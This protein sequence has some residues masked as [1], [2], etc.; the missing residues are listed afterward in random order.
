M[1]KHR[2][3]L[4]YFNR[5]YDE[6][7][8][9]YES[10]FPKSDTGEAWQAA[11]EITPVYMYDPAVPKRIRDC[12]HVD[13]LI[14]ILRHPADRLYSQY[15]KW[16]ALGKTS[17]SFRDFA[18]EIPERM[19]LGRY[20]E[21]IVPFLDYFDESQI[22]VL[23]ME[24]SVSQVDKTKET[25]AKFLGVDASRFP[26]HSGGS[27]SNAGM[28]PDRRPAYM[29]A[30]SLARKLRGQNLD[31][32]VSLAHNLRLKQRLVGKTGTYKPMTPSERDWLAERYAA[33]FDALES[34]LS[35]DVTTWRKVETQS[36]A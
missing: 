19:S 13:R 29:A 25:L 32:I 33:E 20:S 27:A 4:Y 30:R 6:G 9:W 18:E 24:D 1:P 22:L 21:S 31:W 14:A 3:E 26:Q 16:T 35:V 17:L 11:G 5:H 23:V 28:T 2:K 34:R 12:G 7:A 8:D 36:A 15:V 10:F